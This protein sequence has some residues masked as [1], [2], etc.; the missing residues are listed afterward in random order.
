LR[1]WR[2]RCWA[3]SHGGPVSK[4]P[5]H[6]RRRRSDK[7]RCAPCV[8]GSG[9]PAS[10][11]MRASR[12]AML[13]LENRWEGSEPISIRHV[14]IRGGHGDAPTSQPISLPST[15]LHSLGRSGRLLADGPAPR[16]RKAARDDLYGLLCDSLEPINSVHH[17]A[18]LGL[19]RVA[20]ETFLL[21]DP[22]RRG[23]HGTRS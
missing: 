11:V 13:G 2:D 3:T 21:L 9:A 4:K 7:P 1:S 15:H 16:Q 8:M 23:G 5:F 6:H 17:L 22:A 14:P 19:S 20:V 12:A 18:S 10:L